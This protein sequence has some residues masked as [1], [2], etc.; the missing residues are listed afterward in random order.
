V[1][2]LCGMDISE[3]GFEG[4]P[5]ATL[6]SDLVASG[7]AVFNSDGTAAI[8]ITIS[9]TM[10]VTFPERCI[11]GN[12]VTLTC[13]EVEQ[14][15]LESYGESEAAGE[16]ASIDS[17]SCSGRNDCSCVH[18]LVPVTSSSTGTFSVSGNRLTTTDDLGEV[19]D[20]GFC[21][22]GDTLIVFDISDEPG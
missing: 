14:L 15:L 2:G 22:D 18:S 8:E 20:N 17:V 11:T 12:G 3:E 1:D 16:P 10:T 5:R 21:A 9:G 6:T 19:E 13:A 4:C 7:S